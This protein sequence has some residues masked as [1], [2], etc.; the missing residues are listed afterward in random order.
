[1]RK[2]TYFKIHERYWSAVWNILMLF[3]S[4]S[5]LPSPVHP[6]LLPSFLWSISV[7]FYSSVSNP[8]TSLSPRSF[9]FLHFMKMIWSGKVVFT[10]KWT[11][12]K[13]CIPYLVYVQNFLA[14]TLEVKC[15]SEFRIFPFGE[16]YMEYILYIT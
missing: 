2:Q 12:C 11:L 9:S 3:F 7:C 15:V 1:M 4:A 5:S 13:P 14:K 10:V 16:D 6:C 8:T